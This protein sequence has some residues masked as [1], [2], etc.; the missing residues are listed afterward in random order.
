MYKKKAMIGGLDQNSIKQVDNH[1]KR[2]NT[3]KS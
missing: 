1:K 3:T 2:Q